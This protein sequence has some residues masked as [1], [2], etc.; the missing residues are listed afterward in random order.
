[1]RRW[2]EQMAQIGA[3]LDMA[4]LWLTPAPAV[5]SLLPRSALLCGPFCH[6][7][8]VVSLSPS[9]PLLLFLPL[10]LLPTP[11]LPSPSA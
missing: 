3:G 8:W 4:P 6:L 10:S 7:S 9:L 11:I 1:M 2:E 5:L